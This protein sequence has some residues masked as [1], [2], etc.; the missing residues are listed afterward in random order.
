M[1]EHKAKAWVPLLVHSLVYTAVV[2]AFGLIGGGLHPLAVVLLFISHVVLDKRGFTLLWVRHVNKAE[3]LLWMR[4]A[5]D[6]AWHILVLALIT[7]I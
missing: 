5:V 2:A 7:L 6:Q 4:I 3:D 1:A